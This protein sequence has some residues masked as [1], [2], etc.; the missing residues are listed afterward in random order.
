LIPIR[1]T[2]GKVSV[3]SQAPLVVNAAGTRLQVRVPGLATTGDI[4]VV[5]QG[6]DQF[7]FGTGFDAA[8]RNVTM[9]FTAGTS[10]AAIHFADGGLQGLGDE[11]W[12]IDNV[13]VRQ[14][15]T[16]V[17]ADDFEG[18]ASANWSD[19]RTDNFFPLPSIGR[20]SGRF[21]ND[22]GQVLN[23]TGLTPGASYG[24]TFDLLALDSWEGANT[25]TGFG[26][27]LFIVSMDGVTGLI[28]TVSNFAAVNSAQSFRASDGLRVQVVPTLTAISG[29]PG[30]T[31]VYTL[32]GSGFMES[33]STLTIG[34]VALV[35]TLDHDLFDVSGSDS[36]TTGFNNSIGA[37]TP[38][39]LEGPVRV[40]TEGG[41][42]EIMPGF[43]SQ[44][45]RSVTGIV[46]S[47]S[48]GV[49]AN[50]TAPSVN[51][52]QT[53]LLQGGGFTGSN[54]VQFQGVDDSGALGTMTR[55]VGFT[56]SNGG[57]LV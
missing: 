54:Q 8:H 21:S 11:S 4:R 17:F 23:L 26:P 48:L 2:T 16:V 37:R 13:V 22:A 18:G 12:G 41:F 39:T 9:D 51:T 53:I 44:A 35:D 29:R 15:E 14:G 49:A 19:Q 40:T 10:T 7:E 34:G 43:D 42:A 45:I 25:S 47:A 1:D 24:L 30:E 36:I 3:V 32:S 52:G 33:A 46:A 55:T 50:P 38:R 20:F 31:G 27:D 57:L 56:A 5:N 28:E 6:T